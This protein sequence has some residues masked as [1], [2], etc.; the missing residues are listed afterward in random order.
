ML[1][2]WTVCVTLIRRLHGLRPRLDSLFACH[3]QSPRFT[4]GHA[5]RQVGKYIT[6]LSQLIAYRLGRRARIVNRE[7]PA[8]GPFGQIVYHLAGFGYVAANRSP[9]PVLGLHT[10]DSDV[11]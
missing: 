2:D 4:V 7:N 6:V 10:V 9:R 8:P 5:L 11:E 1:T 3:Q